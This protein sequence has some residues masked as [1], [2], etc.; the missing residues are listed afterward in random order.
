MT[1]VVMTG[2]RIAKVPFA[3]IRKTF[4][5]A[6]ELEARGVRVVH[7]DI[8]RPD[9][10]T[11][12]HIKEAAKSALDQGIVHYAPNAGMPAL[13]EALAAR[14]WEEK[15]IRY[16]ADKE[17]MAT[18]G[19]QEA[20]YLSLMSVLDP[21]DEVLIPDPG[22]S[23]FSTAVHLA[24]GVPVAIDLAASDNF[25][26]NLEMAAKAISARTRAMIVNSPH[27]PSGSVLTREQLEKIAGFAAK[28]NLILISDEAYDHMVYEGRVHYSPASFP[29]MR[30]RTIVCGSLSKTY[31]MTGWR[32]GYIAAP[33]AVI[34]AA[35]RVQQNV[36]LSL[37]AFAQMGAIAALTQSQA[38]T[39]EM[40]NELGRRRK[41]VLER[42]KLVPGLTLEN[43]PYGT[44]YVFPKITVPGITSAQ[45]AEHLL[46]KN[47]IALIDG[48]AF[49]RNGAGH[50]RLSYSCSYKNCEEGM[51]RLHEAMTKLVTGRERVAQ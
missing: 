32:I 13:R 10:D 17:I 49:G 7:F 42:I 38:F 19:G 31:A 26:F 47:G 40:M 28:H 2:E 9:F 12:A 15:G 24:G 48:N 22:F 36:M 5:K 51:E 46:D 25:T 30:E 39:A 45:L 29:G 20:L 44:F 23:T 14:V 34:G 50:L 16:D 18:A 1:N 35:I 41:L 6:N 11:P 3:G 43:D 37:C 21:G 27:N 33:E 8:G 4:E